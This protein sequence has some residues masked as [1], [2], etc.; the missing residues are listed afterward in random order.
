MVELF[1]FYS[2]YKWILY[3]NTNCNQKRLIVISNNFSMKYGPSNKELKFVFYHW[4]KVIYQS[5]DSRHRM[6]IRQRE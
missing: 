5:L 2:Y 1:T 3:I 4:L 6:T